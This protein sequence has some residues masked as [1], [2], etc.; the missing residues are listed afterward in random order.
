MAHCRE[1]RMPSCPS[2]RHNVHA[3]PPVVSSGAR[4][5]WGFGSDLV[6]LG[7]GHNAMQVAQDVIVQIENVC[8]DFL[9]GASRE[10][11]AC[12]LMAQYREISLT[13][14]WLAK[15]LKSKLAAIHWRAL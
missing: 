1:N 14:R 7:E 6:V 3:M 13:A 8:D 9:R 15:R 4:G 2:C 10:T 5:G 11:R 12:F